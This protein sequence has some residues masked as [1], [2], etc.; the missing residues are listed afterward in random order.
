MPE[1][2]NRKSATLSQR[3]DPQLKADLEELARRDDR[4]LTNFVQH[5]L[6]QAVAA[7]KEK[8]GRD[9]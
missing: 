6:K 2:E 1:D 5:I 3:I 4:S 7:R 8:P 9:R